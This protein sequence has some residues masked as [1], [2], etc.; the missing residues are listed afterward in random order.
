MVAVDEVVATVATMKADVR[1]VVK[2]VTKKDV[3]IVVKSVTTSDVATVNDVAMES[4]V[5]N[6]REVAV[7]IMTVRHLFHAS[8][9]LDRLT[10]ECSLTFIFSPGE[11]RGGGGGGQMNPELKAAVD[12]ASQDREE[13]KNAPDNLKPQCA[14]ACKNSEAEVV[15]LGGNPSMIRGQAPGEHRGGGDGPGREGH[16]EGRGGHG[17]GRGRG[18]HGRDD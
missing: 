5:V 10:V 18:G 8:F 13:W 14:E 9:T 4:D 12:N 15:R 3:R 16:H 6:M 17:G 11:G 2:S 1:N 7:D